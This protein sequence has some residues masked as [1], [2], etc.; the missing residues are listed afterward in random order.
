M[1]VGNGRGVTELFMP[2]DESPK[3][4]EIWSGFWVRGQAVLGKGG[5]GEARVLGDVVGSGCC[6]AFNGEGIHLPFALVG[7][8]A[9]PNHVH[10]NDPPCLMCWAKHH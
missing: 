10:S 1:D 6:E 2:F 3:C 5:F 7:M 4:H 9:S 8:L